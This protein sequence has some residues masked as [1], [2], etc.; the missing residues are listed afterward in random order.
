VRR[1]T[2]V[3]AVALLA[4][5]ALAAGARLVVGAVEIRVQPGMRPS[6]PPLAPGSALGAPVALNDAAA[7]TGFALALPA[8]A[9]PD[10]T[11]VY[12]GELGATGALLAWDAADRYPPLPG[13]P[14]GLVLMEISA[15]REAVVK[16]VNAFE[17][18]RRLTFDGA[19]AFWI[20]APHELTVI[21]AAGDRSFAVGGNVLIW[22]RGDIT[23]RM[24][25]ALPLPAALARAR[26]IG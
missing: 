4:L 2:V 11:Y 25:T 1:R 13:T 9:P 12:D 23:F 7:A 18:T 15:D 6:G 16:T 8:G 24:E 20:D 5:G 26:P 17:D 10:R 3:A 22:K 14:W 21:T 19:R